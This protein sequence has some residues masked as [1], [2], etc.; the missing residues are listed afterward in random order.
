L[1]KW[2]QDEVQK[3]YEELR[4]I[5]PYARLQAE[6]TSYLG[7]EC[8]SGIQNYLYK[9]VDIEKAAGL[10]TKERVVALEDKCTD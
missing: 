4:G 9:I 7:E 2:K 10:V 6:R 1:H 8:I 5:I 3:K